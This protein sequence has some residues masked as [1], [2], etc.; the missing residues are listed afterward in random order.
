MGDG[1]HRPLNADAMHVRTIEVSN[2]GVSLTAVSGRKIK[3]RRPR[4]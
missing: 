2:F 4:L 1:D 3:D